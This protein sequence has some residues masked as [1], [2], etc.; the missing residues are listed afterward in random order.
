LFNRTKIMK[1]V[2]FL[3]SFIFFL[4]SINA[5]HKYYGLKSNEEISDNIQKISEKTGVDVAI[6]EKFNNSVV[7]ENEIP[8][9]YIGYILEENISPEQ[10]ISVCKEMFKSV[11]VSKGVDGNYS[12]KEFHNI[13]IS[14]LNGDDIVLPMK[15]EKC[16][17]QGTPS[18]KTGEDCP[19]C[20]GCCRKD[21]GCPILPLSESGIINH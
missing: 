6:L 21:G 13:V 11:F 10:Y 9:G 17:K 19:E 2:F 18:E 16:P 8:I 1:K 14:K 15:P 3:L 7:F 4:Q 5:Q 20:S 12:Q